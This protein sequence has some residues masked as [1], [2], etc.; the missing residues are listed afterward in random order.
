MPNQVS[1]GSLDCI[2]NGEL[3]LPPN[4]WHLKGAGSDES[5]LKIGVSLDFPKITYSWDG[6]CFCEPVLARDGVPVLA[7]DDSAILAECRC[8]NPVLADSDNPIL[9]TP[10]S[11]IFAT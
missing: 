1:L 9:A 10:D 6:S 5:P 4:R 2:A 7:S 8:S 11:E 3:H